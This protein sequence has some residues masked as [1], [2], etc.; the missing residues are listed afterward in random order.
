MKADT[1]ESKGSASLHDG[2]PAKGEA[3]L[4]PHEL[5]VPPSQLCGVEQSLWLETF[6]VHWFYF[7][8]DFFDKTLSFFLFCTFSSRGQGKGGI[9]KSA[10]LRDSL[11]F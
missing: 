3:E 10:P 2:E 8:A 1:K 11:F 9:P 6:R 7:L 5:S 4:D